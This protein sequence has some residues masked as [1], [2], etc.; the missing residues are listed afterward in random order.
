MGADINPEWYYPAG[1]GCVLVWG[2]VWLIKYGCVVCGLAKPC[3]GVLFICSLGF[4]YV[5]GYWSHIVFVN[6]G[7]VHAVATGIGTLILNQ[8][9]YFGLMGWMRKSPKLS[10]V[11]DA[12]RVKRRPT[13]KAVDFDVTGGSDST[14][15][16]H[17][18]MFGD[19]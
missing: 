18:T 3:N 19:H 7:E 4:G 13:K 1:V 17:T 5:F 11:Y 12:L 9:F 2:V 10:G 14:M 6:A 15:I 16:N 8:P